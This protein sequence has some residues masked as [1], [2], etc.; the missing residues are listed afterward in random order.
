MT[1]AWHDAKIQT[2]RGSRWKIDVLKAGT[3]S[4]PTEACKLREF[5][6]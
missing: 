1:N 4:K 6:S 2:L 3:Q 5:R